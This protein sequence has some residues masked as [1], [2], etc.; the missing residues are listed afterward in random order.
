M[1]GDEGEWTR[2]RRRRGARPSAPPACA[3]PGSFSPA[4]SGAV[5]H[6]I[7]AEAVRVEQSIR[8]AAAQ[9]EKS[10]FYAELVAGLEN[11]VCREETPLGEGAEEGDDESFGA[12][13]PSEDGSD[14]SDSSDLEPRLESTRRAGPRSDPVRGAGH[15]D[16]RVRSGSSRA[17]HPMAFSARPFTRVVA[18]GV[19]SP[20]RSREPS[21]VHQAALAHLLSQRYGVL[22]HMYDPVMTSADVEAYKRLGMLVPPS[23]AAAEKLWSP[24]KSTLLYCAHC[25]RDLTR[26]VLERSLR[27]GE[28]RS[29]ELMPNPR[30]DEFIV[31]L[32][33]RIS[34]WTDSPSERSVVTPNDGA[35]HTSRRLLHTLARRNHVHQRD[36]PQRGYPVVS[37]FNDLAIHSFWRPKGADHRHSSTVPSLPCVSMRKKRSG[38]RV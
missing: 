35:S 8:R 25:S 28:D 2:P 18:L 12:S 4:A 3:L 23:D 13:D 36:V 19:G 11:V 21:I 6:E 20:S 38:W 17:A 14:D 29:G 33:N 32:G 22:C 1:S 7:L 30:D 26:S 10:A 9:L 34:N 16:R 24:E 37:A 5:T 15:S 31:C 27:V